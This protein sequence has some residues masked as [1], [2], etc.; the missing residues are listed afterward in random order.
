MHFKYQL[1]FVNSILES[2]SI[3]TEY[4][5]FRRWVYLESLSNILFARMLHGSVIFCLTFPRCLT[6]NPQADCH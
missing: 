6:L 2:E 4:N 1:S 3:W 5:A